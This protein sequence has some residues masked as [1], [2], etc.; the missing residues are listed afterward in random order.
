MKKNVSKTHTQMMDA[1][2][3]ELVAKI[4]AV[5]TDETIA[6]TTRGTKLYHLKHELKTLRLI[7]ELLSDAE[8]LSKDAIEHLN[9]LI[10]PADERQQKF[11][12]EE[13]EQLLD[14]MQRYPNKKKLIEAINEYCGE[15]GLMLDTTAMKIVKA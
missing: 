5:S 4:A 8:S 15:H 13:G 1:R 14:I 6:K 7:N 10:K 3:K 9:G 2:V 11:Y 12:V